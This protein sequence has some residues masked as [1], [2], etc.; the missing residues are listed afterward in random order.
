[1][2]LKTKV[3]EYHELTDQHIKRWC[4]LEERSVE[5]NA[6]L[7][8]FFI[9]PALKHFP[10][11]GRPMIV[12][13]ETGGGNTGDLLGVGVFECS[14]RTIQVP[15]SHLKAYRCPHAYLTGFL[16]DKQH[17]EETTDAFFSFFH[18]ARGDW[19]GVEFVNRRKES[20]LASRFD[21][22]SSRLN[23]PWF[24]YSR[25]QRSILLPER[26]GESNM[27]TVLASK[28]RK[29][30]RQNLRRLND[31]GK[32]QWRVIT[33]REIEPPCLDTFLELEHTGWKKA[34][35]SSLLSHA[36]DEAFFREMM[37]GFA[38]SGRAFFTE[39]SMNGKVIASTSNLISG[40]AGFA[41]K[42]GWDEA[43]SKLGPGILN[44]VEFMKYFPELLPKIRY[45]DSGAENGSFIE[46]LWPDQISLVSG[47]Y[48]SNPRMK[49]LFQGIDF[50]RKVKR[51]L[52]N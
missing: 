29:I 22:A 30:L 19:C 3:L 17:A 18:G 44:E 28:R 51:R 6:Y 24:E 1:M 21:I 35:N 52:L 45:V 7:S 4:E 41:F 12:F 46:K 31:L 15:V 16:V 20:E 14:P 5:E 11:R 40:V 13:I 32:V 50:I 34:K 43:F 38:Q 9:L 39:L 49:P 23:I 27:K 25:Q 26:C 2:N 36:K 33:G 37:N 10:P 48:L 42:I 8:P 47:F